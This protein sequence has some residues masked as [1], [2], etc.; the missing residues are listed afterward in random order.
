LSPKQFWEVISEEHGI[1]PVGTHQEA[2]SLQ[3]ER[4]GVYFNQASG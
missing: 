4:I 2:S 1:D 3:L